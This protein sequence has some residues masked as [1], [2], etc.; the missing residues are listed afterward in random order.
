MSQIYWIFASLLPQNDFENLNNK[1]THFALFRFQNCAVCLQIRCC[2]RRGFQLLHSRP[3]NFSSPNGLPD[4]KV[5]N[6][7]I[8]HIAFTSR[9]ITGLFRLLFLRSSLIGNLE[10]NIWWSKIKNSAS[11]E[12]VAVNN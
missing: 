7:E 5:L 10:N 3:F 9:F 11:K 12:T 1:F 6:F 4:I 2:N 8:F